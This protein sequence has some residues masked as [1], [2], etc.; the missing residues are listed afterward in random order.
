M[1]FPRCSPKRRG[2]ST[3][4]FAHR[5]LLGPLGIEAEFW[6][7]D[8]Q[9]FFTGGHSVSFTAREIRPLWIALSQ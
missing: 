1:C 4:E 7:I 6:G 2:M 9:G 8:P 3:C 5:Y